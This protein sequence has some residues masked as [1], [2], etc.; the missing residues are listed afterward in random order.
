M[1]VVLGCSGTKKT[2]LCI[3]L[4]RKLPIEIINADATLV[5][6]GMDIGTDKPTMADRQGVPHHLIDTHDL[7]QEVS[8]AEWRD[9]AISTIRSVLDR[10]NT[11][12]VVG[13]SM[14]YMR[15]LM[16]KFGH[17]TQDIS[18]V[19]E[20]RKELEEKIS[21]VLGN[22]SRVDQAVNELIRIAGLDL[23]SEMLEY[24]HTSVKREGL[25][26]ARRLTRVVEICR[27][28]QIPQA[29]SSESDPEFDWR[30]VG[31]V[32]DRLLMY[33][34]VDYRVECMLKQGLV[35]EVRGLRDSGALATAAKSVTTAIGYRQSLEYLE[36]KIDGQELVAKIQAASRSLVKRQMTWM[37]N[38]LSG[39]FRLIDAFP[40]QGMEM[41]MDWPTQVEDMELGV[42]AR[43]DI[44]DKF[45]YTLECPRE[46]YEQSRLDQSLLE[47]DPKKSELMKRYAPK[48]WVY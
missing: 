35:D 45:Q 1:L 11:P 5:Y 46:E 15:W 41:T 30:S 4:G 40:L 16:Y 2:Q 29:F 27:S 23:N 20:H 39:S 42:Q 19:L 13:G 18:G 7:S 9:S 10:G 24:I 33:R 17:E 32:A 28:G 36:G 47:L 34:K 37:R 48:H 12:V 6:R 3:D 38:N 22:C 21:R 8:V 25:T 14:L 31:L 43:E 44:V 26:N